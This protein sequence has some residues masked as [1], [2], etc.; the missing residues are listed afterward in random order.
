VTGGPTARPFRVTV[1]ASSSERIDADYLQAAEELGRRI[2]AAGFEL[3]WGGGRYGAMGAVSRGAR[4]AGGRTLGVILQQFID[5]NVHCEQAHA[6]TTLHDMR[7]RKRGLDELGDA[8]VALP[9]GLGTL[10]ELLEVMSFKQLGL[11]DKPIV[12]LNTRGYWQPLLDMLE[13][14]FGQGFIQP[15]CRGLWTVAATPAEAMTC[16]GAP[17]WQAG[18]VDPRGGGTG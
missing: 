13:R 14:G 6:M 7:A 5:K 4:A 11:H 10:E 15:H 17:G 9:G 8:F 1:Y 18:A 12:V 16:L 2:A 3:V